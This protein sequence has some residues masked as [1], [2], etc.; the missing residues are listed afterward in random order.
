MSMSTST[1]KYSIR[2]IKATDNARVADIILQ[3]M[4]S[5]GCIG[6]GYS[7]SD[8]EVKTMY[9]SY[10]A[11][12]HS[13][14]VIV[15]EAEIPW[16]CGGIAPLTG[17]EGS[18]CELRKM[19]F[20]PE[21]RGNGWGQR[22]IETCIESAKEHGYQSM[23]LETIHAMKAANHLYEKNGFKLLDG[24]KG[25]TGHSGCDAWRIKDLV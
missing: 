1:N 8:P 20:L 2:S 14:F 5:F 3:V 22:M 10:T 4:T 25:C 7:S 9:E 13:F 6:E 23:Y 19:Y 15:D 21:L 24:A 11:P 16:G 12:G 17:D 18:I